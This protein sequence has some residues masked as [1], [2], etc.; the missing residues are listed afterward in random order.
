MQRTLIWDLPTRLFHWALAASFALAYITSEGDRWRSVHVFFGYLILGLVVFRLVWGFAGS[1]FSR[2]DSFWFSPKASLGYLKQVLSRTAPRHVGHNPTGSMAIYILLALAVVVGITGVLTLGGD[3]QQGLAAGFFSFSQIKLI[4][5][6]HELFANGM[7]LV[8]FGHIA[9]VVVESVLHK[10]NLARSM[11][12]GF[13]MA[14][15]DTPLAKQ[16]KVIA[17]LMLVSMLGF[18]GWWFYYAID[19]TMEG[20]ESHVV[21]EDVNKAEELHVKFVGKTLPDNTQWREECGSC[22]GVFYP[23]LLPARS[24]EKIMAE[25]AQHF[26]SDLG[27]DEATTKSVLAF[28]VANSAEKHQI[29]AGYKIESSLAQVATPLRITETP[30]WIKKHREIAASDWANPLVKSKS[31]CSACH[32]D[33]EVGTYEDAAM[34]MPKAPKPVSSATTAAKVKP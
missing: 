20:Q 28:M 17:G 25:Q 15:A 29:E 4:K 13:K 5:K 1:H 27:L 9:G 19:R 3:E 21:K 6:L 12:T 24:W 23:A 31:N 2:F 30:Y 18:A 32:V 10:E 7:L 11:V 16:S 26:G 8:V 22:H 14:G 33:A 34:R